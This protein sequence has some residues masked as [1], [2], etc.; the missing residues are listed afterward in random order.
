MFIPWLPFIL[1]EK[2]EINMIEKN[3]EL[4]VTNRSNVKVVYSVPNLHV[5]REFA[6]GQT[7]TITYDELANLSYQPGGKVLMANYL[8]IKDPE[9]RDYK[10][11]TAEPE[12]YYTDEEVIKLLTEGSLDEFLDAL[13]FAPIGVIDLIKKYSL[14]LPLNDVAKREALLKKEKFNVTAMLE[15]SKE[16]DE[17]ESEVQTKGRRVKKDVEEAPKPKRRAKATETAE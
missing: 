11:D 14:E 5:Q 6:P 10:N 8:L 16:L 3:K 1:L 7:L 13:D 17:K 2:K 12:Y 15:N 9:D 4:E